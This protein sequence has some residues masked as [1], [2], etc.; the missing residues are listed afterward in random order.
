MVGQ[1]GAPHPAPQ[2]RPHRSLDVRE[3]PEE[4]SESGQAAR[5]GREAGVRVTDHASKEPLRCQHRAY[6]G[7]TVLGEASRLCRLVVGLVGIASLGH[8]ER[9][10]H[11][12]LRKVPPAANS[13]LGD[14]WPC[15]TPPGEQGR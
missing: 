4:A 13:N 3:D 11:I 1:H 12:G 8:Q 14:I 15:P 10:P 6:G 7:P 2:E 5:L 9:A